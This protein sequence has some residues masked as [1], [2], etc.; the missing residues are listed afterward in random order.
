MSSTACSP[1]R[2]SLRRRPCRRHFW[3]GSSTDSPNPVQSTVDQN[4]AAQDGYEYLTVKV[5]P[6]R[7][8]KSDQRKHTRALNK[9]AAEGW[10]LVESQPKGVLEWGRKD[11]VNFRRPR[12]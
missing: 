11:T 12:S 5:P 8:A 7:G 2:T 6:A 10:E 4:A 3:I 9:Y 1:T